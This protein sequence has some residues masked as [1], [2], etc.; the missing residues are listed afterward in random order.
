MNLVV[1]II[2]SEFFSYLVVGGL[3]ALIYFGFLALSVE[4]FTLDY[5]LGVSIAYVLAVS[6][7][8]LAN[9]KFTFRIVDD[10]VIHQ[11]MRY[12]GVLIVNYL[13]MLSIVSFFVDKLGI[14]TYFSAAISIVVTVSVGYLASKFWVFRNKESLRD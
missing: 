7:H 6:F 4:V 12:L 2:N 1:K 14:S 8:F 10:R 11:W 13:I 5:R 9:R 3:T